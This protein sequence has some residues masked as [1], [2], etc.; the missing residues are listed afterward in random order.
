LL[1]AR[2]HV[3]GGFLVACRVQEGSDCYE[4]WG[5]CWYTP[6]VRNEILNQFDGQTKI[7][8]KCIRGVS[9]QH[10]NT[11]VSTIMRHLTITRVAGAIRIAYVTWPHRHITSQRIR[12]GSTGQNLNTTRTFRMPVH[13]PKP[14]V[15]YPLDLT[16]VHTFF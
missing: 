14:Y 16:P 2:L 4:T 15:L 8:L 6:T 3:V 7:M 5:L 10:I 11:C 12:V 1:H 13:M 9:G